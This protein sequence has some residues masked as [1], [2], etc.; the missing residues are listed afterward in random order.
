M[1]TDVVKLR[2]SATIVDRLEK[3]QAVLGRPMAPGRANPDNDLFYL[4]LD[5]REHIQEVERYAR[6]LEKALEGR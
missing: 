4:L 1:I 2:E 3:W 5:A 6:H